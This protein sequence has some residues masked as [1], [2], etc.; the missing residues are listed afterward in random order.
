MGIGILYLTSIFWM[1]SKDQYED[2]V[3]KSYWSFFANRLFFNIIIGPVI[4]AVIGF[5]NWLNQTITQEKRGFRSILMIDLLIFTIC[6]IVFTALQ[7]A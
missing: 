6:S 3:N 7:L 4:V 1:G 2:L 5:I